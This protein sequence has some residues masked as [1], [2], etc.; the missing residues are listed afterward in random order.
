MRYTSL[1]VVFTSCSLKLLRRLSCRRFALYDGV[2]RLGMSRSFL[3][4]VIFV[5]CKTG[6]YATMTVVSNCCIPIGR[7]IDL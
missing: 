4:R 5:T 7:Q 6:L 2:N 3:I 1:Q